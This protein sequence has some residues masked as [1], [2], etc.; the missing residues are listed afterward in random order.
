[1]I[2][3]MQKRIFSA[4][5]A[6]FLLLGIGAGS[7]MADDTEPSA[8]PTSQAD[9][10]KEAELKQKLTL[11]NEAQKG[12]QAF[13]TFENEMEKETTFSYDDPYTYKNPFEFPASGI[14][15][16][17]TRLEQFPLRRPLGLP[18]IPTQPRFSFTE[19]DPHSPGL[20][21]DLKIPPE[22]SPIFR[23][24]DDFEAE[25]DE[26]TG[27]KLAVE[28][29]EDEP[30]YIPLDVNDT[31]N[32]AKEMLDTTKDIFTLEELYREIIFEHPDLEVAIATIL[33]KQGNVMVSQALGNPRIGS[34]VTLG[35]MWTDYI[36]GTPSSLDWGS[37]SVYMTQTLFDFGAVENNVMADTLSKESASVKL[38]ST[39]YSVASIITQYY[40]NVIQAQ[41]VVQMRHNEVLFYQSLRDVLLKRQQ[42]GTGLMTDVQKIDVSLKTA[43]SGLINEMQ[44]LRTFR[45]MLSTLLGNKPVGWLSIEESLFARNMNVSLLDLQ[46]EALKR[47]FSII[48]IDKDIQATKFKIKSMEVDTLPKFGY[49]LSGGYQAEYPANSFYGG[50]QATVSWNIYDG[51]EHEGQIAKLRSTLYKQQATRKSE[52]IAMIDRIKSAYNDYHVASKDLELAHNGKE[53]S[54]D[55]TKKYLQEF[56][57]GLRTLLDLVTAKSGEIEADLREVNSRFRCV[58]GL[59]QLYNEVGLLEKYL[60]MPEGIIQSMAQRFGIQVKD[61]SLLLD[62]PRGPETKATSGATGNPITPAWGQHE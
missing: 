33:E 23:K 6:A 50:A 48:S 54:M 62:T 46:E 18:I 7:A 5:S 42:A 35:P 34:D 25:L 52:T 17:P 56:D 11:R 19:A 53:I 21:E 3:T 47:N 13:D 16:L 27:Q 58:A 40:L 9:Q 44:R 60:P 8:E 14:K 32:L 10:L 49:K 51:G 41:E 61:M 20:A 15:E 39:S 55:L 22:D 45:N 57:I 36:D 24:A 59:M 30:P 28:E 2:Y 1:M 26:E 43:E 4:L 29:K 31:L 37:G 12:P 38:Y